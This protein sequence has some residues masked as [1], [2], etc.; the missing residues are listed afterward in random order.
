M[1]PLDLALVLVYAM[2]HVY[3]NTEV[4]RASNPEIFSFMLQVTGAVMA[5]GVGL[6]AGG[7]F[8][9]PLVGWGCIGGAGLAYAG[10]YTTIAK[11][12]ERGDLSL[13][14]PIARG[15]APVASALLG[16]ALYA[17]HPT[18][19]GIVGI[20][21]VCLGGVAGSA[22]IPGAKA[23]ISTAGVLLAVATG[24]MTAVYSA[25]DKT[26]SNM[27][28]P[29]L[30]MGLSFFVG[31][32]G[33]WLLLRARKVPIELGGMKPLNLMGASIANTFGYLLILIVLRTSPM[34]YVVPLKSVAVV[35][36]LIVGVMLFKEQVDRRRVLSVLVILAGLVAIALA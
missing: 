13:A 10:Y 2:A 26:G 35:L 32:C 5:I 12:Y 6:L 3:W 33:H 14:Y 34:S 17:E 18:W 24:L 19:L 15:T 20:A 7:N 27:M 30:Y 9:F 8:S 11:S 31:A 16:I 4:K 29:L 21:L 36:S 25:F 23:R 1:S 22:N 28:Q